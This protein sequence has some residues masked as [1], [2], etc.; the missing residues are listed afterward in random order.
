[1]KGLNEHPLDGVQLP[2]GVTW[3]TYSSSSYP[4]L[5]VTRLFLKT[6]QIH[7]YKRTKRDEIALLTRNLE[8][9]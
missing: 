4:P 9:L 8:M 6:Q 7:L 3:V 1:M 5:L 2:R